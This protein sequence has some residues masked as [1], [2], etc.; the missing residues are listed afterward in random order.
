MRN[1]RP[2]QRHNAVA[3]DLVH[4]ALVAV[5]RLH[6]GVQGGVEELTRLFGIKTLD[7]LRGTLDIGKQ[8]SDLL[9][10]AFQVATRRQNFLREVFGSVCLRRYEAGWCSGSSLHRLP[11]FEA[12]LGA[13]RQLSATPGTRQH[14]TGAALQA[15]LRLRRIFLLALEAL[16]T[17]APLSRLR[18]RTRRLMRR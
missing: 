3:Q 5:H 9:A 13:R 15:E 4:R 6:H 12:K 16:H 14:Q 10:L 8:H 11:A 1:G 2:K 18:P 17:E 7:E